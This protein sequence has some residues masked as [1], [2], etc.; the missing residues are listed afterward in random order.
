MLGQG[1]PELA[2]PVAATVED[3]VRGDGCGL[4]AAIPLPLE[5]E[6]DLIVIR[7]LAP[8][9]VEGQRLVPQARLEV[10]EAGLFVVIFEAPLHLLQ[11]QVQTGDPHLVVAEGGITARLDLAFAIERNIELDRTSH[12][13][14]DLDLRS[15]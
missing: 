3:T 1:Q 14:A 9:I 11:R 6:V 15:A 4:A 2:A 7:M 13:A 5:I 10:A 12:R 8:L